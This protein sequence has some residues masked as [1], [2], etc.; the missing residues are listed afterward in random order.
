MGEAKHRVGIFGNMLNFLQER[1][2]K[3]GQTRQKLLLAFNYFS[4]NEI[5]KKGDE[6]SMKELILVILA[7]DVITEIFY[8][9]RL[10]KERDS[11][12][13]RATTHFKR[14]NNF[15]KQLKETKNEY[16]EQAEILLDNASEYRTTIIELEE[17]KNKVTDIVES[18]HFAHDKVEK[19]KELISDYQSQ[20]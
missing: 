5:K 7:L 20:N 18:E 16:E 12:E 13:E 10:Q 8:I 15:E 6:K 17:F 19:I 4:K 9:R 11:A 2:T 1:S 14:A 3:D